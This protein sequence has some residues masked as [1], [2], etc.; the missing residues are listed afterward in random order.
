MKIHVHQWFKLCPWGKKSAQSLESQIHI[1]LFNKFFKWLS[2]TLANLM[3]LDRIYPPV[4]STKIDEMVMLASITKSR[5][6]WWA[7]QDP[8]GPTCLPLF[9]YN[10]YLITNWVNHIFVDKAQRDPCFLQIHYATNINFLQC[11]Y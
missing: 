4:A 7:T 6:L 3:K 2:H 10:F 11:H 1:E 9:L 8:Q 5:G